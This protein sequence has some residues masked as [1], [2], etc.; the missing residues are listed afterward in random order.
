MPVKVNIIGAG[1]AGLYAG[2]LIKRA[3]PDAEVR[4]FE[5]NK[6]NATFG[7]GVVFSDQALAFL[8]HDD[9][10]T[11]ALIEPHMKRW[12]DISVV[13]RNRRVLIDGIGFAGINRMNL[14]RLLQRRA[15]A[16]G[17]NLSFE[18]RIDSLDQLS[19]A[20]LVVAA[21][22]LNS[23]VRSS[24]PSVFGESIRHLSNRFAWFGVERE[25]DTL[26]QTFITSPAGPMNAHHY[27][28]EAGLSTF[29]IEMTPSTFENTQFSEMTESERR[30]KCE[31]Y[32]AQQLGTAKLISNHSVWRRFP[33]LSCQTWHHDNMVLVGD[34]LHTAHFSIGSGTRLA[35]EDVIALVK[36]LRLK[37]WDISAAL[38]AYQAVRQPILEKII[39]AAKHSANWYEHF[40][41]HMELK[42]WQFALSY[43]RRAGR[44]D[45]ERLQRLAPLF[46]QQL[47]ARGID[48]ETI[49]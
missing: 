30:E 15:A 25:Y 43:M 33:V 29:I 18:A 32:F 28:Y 3:R 16:M 31:Q 27:S 37:D 14:L 47:I 9:P 4:I 1:P 48:L 42:P 19:G 49:G 11:A 36:S 13:H 45:S 24:T 10:D 46:T 21:D 41:Q 23:M 8:Q 38:P 2:I 5:Q 12:T 22:G 26:T 7:F 39:T 17:V 20:N 40:D 35:L 44:I 6:A 34:A